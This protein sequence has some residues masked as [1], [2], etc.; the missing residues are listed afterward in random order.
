[1]RKHYPDVKVEPYRESMWSMIRR[2]RIPPLR[3]ARFCCRE[4]KE[5]GGVGRI[6]VAGIRAAESSRR[7]KSY[8][9]VNVQ[10]KN[11]KKRV[12][13]FD[14][15]QGKQLVRSC[16]TGGK[17]LVTPIFKWGDD[18]VWNFIHS[19]NLPY[20]ELYDQGFDRLG[21]IGCP[22]AGKRGRELAFKRYPKFMNAYIR[23]FD[24]IVANPLTQNRYFHKK[25][26]SGR[27]MFDWW[28]SDKSHKMKIDLPLLK[29]MGLE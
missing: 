27:E 28:M 15:E 2:Y 1:M 11:P 23:A 22:M 10:H 29:E 25:F 13:T 7:A 4:L 3:T 12:F 16:P 8:G 5:R 26:K 18:D 21:C 9:T 17:V 19:R 14:P 20:C 6:I 24:D